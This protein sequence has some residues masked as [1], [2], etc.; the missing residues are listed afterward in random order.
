[1]A[2]D[3][4]VKAVDIS[5]DCGLRLGAGLEDGALYEFGL[6]RLEEGG[7]LR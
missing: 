4:V 7:H 6:Q 2:P 1:M 5:A 3:R